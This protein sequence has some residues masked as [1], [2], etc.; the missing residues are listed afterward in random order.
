[1]VSFF[2]FSEKRESLQC[3]LQDLLYKVK[4]HV[5]LG[6]PFVVYLYLERTGYLNRDFIASMKRRG[7]GVYRD[8][9]QISYM[10]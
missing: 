3:L 6:T 5:H 2:F 9:L 8:R 7:D 1:M 4:D 10:L